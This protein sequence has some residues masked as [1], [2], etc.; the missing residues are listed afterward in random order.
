MTFAASSVERPEP[1]A[2]DPNPSVSIKGGSSAA[3][4]RSACSCTR[5]WR[6][7]LARSCATPVFAMPPAFGAGP[8]RSVTGLGPL[9]VTATGIC[10]QGA[11]PEVAS[12]AAGNGVFLWSRRR[13]Q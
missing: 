12:V 7:R 10:Q 1:S 9:Q 11:F 6:K 5:W 2:L 8:D 3:R 4:A 13:L